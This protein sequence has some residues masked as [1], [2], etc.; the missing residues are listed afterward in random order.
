MKGITNMKLLHILR[1]SF[2][3]FFIIAFATL[4]SSQTRLQSVVI[5]EGGSKTSNSSTTLHYTIGQAAVGKASNSSMKGQFGFWNDPLQ[6]SSVPKRGTGAISG[7]T[8]SPNPA[9]AF[10]NINVTLR[11]AGMLDLYLYNDA[12]QEVA[13]IFSGR[14][15]A[16]NYSV[17]FN[18][19]ELPVG[20]YFIAARVPGALMESRFVVVR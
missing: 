2:I 17:L 19:K 7:V 11:S 9:S 15:D 13:K 10:T 14:K 1:L 6:T 3:V 5:S 16:G 8:V 4:G 12:G 18:T 20:A